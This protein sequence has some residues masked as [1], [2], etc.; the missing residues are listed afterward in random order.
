MLGLTPQYDHMIMIDAFI[1]RRKGVKS[2]STVNCILF[3]LT[4]YEDVRS[5]KK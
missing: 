4:V 5:D 2:P 3:L 1:R